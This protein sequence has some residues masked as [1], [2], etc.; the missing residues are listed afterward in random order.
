MFLARETMPFGSGVSGYLLS[1]SCV[2]PACSGQCRLPLS[3]GQALVLDFAICG[4][5][6]LSHGDHLHRRSGQIKNFAH[7][8]THRLRVLAILHDDDEQIVVA[9]ARHRR[10]EAAREDSFQFIEVEALPE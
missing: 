9:T 8:S 2:L 10:F 5:W 7:Y 1:P 6:Q 4:S 3:V